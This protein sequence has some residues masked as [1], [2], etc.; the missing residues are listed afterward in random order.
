MMILGGAIL[1]VVQGKLADTL[2]IQTSYV[3]AMGCFIYLFI[4]G[5]V[6]QKVLRKQG[7]D[8]DKEV[9]NKAV[10]GGH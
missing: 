8:F 4:F 3:L 7:I 2:G 6:T 10:K 5:I 9:A 1:P